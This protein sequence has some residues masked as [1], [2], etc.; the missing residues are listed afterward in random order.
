[1][2]HENHLQTIVNLRQ[3][4]EA[5][6]N[7]LALVIVGSA[8]RGDG[9]PSSDVDFFLVTTAEEHAKRKAAHELSIC[10]TDLAVAPCPEANG[11]VITEAW[12]HNV[13]DHGTEP[14]RYSFTDAKVVLSRLPGIEAL[15]QRCAA[16][17]EHERTEKMV[18][19]VSQIP[20]HFSFLEFGHYSQTAYVLHE[21]A[22]KLVLF[23]GR[24]LLAHNRMLYPGRKWFQ[25]ELTKAPDKPENFIELANTLLN[26]PSIDTA[27]IF[28][29][30]VL[31]HADWPYPPEGIGARFRYD[32]VD[33]WERGWCPLEEC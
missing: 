21:T 13:A 12:L 5:D 6:P 22:V 20:V 8:A 26:A 28:M 7:V 25:R 23:G 9:F 24:L 3:Y 14:F 16:Y 32:S 30:T 10:R 27:R 17:P 18:S 15:I 2:M 33:L 19:F 4:F 1:M 11:T 31:N 29:D